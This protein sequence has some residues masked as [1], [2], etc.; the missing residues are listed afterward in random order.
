M[1]I[2]LIRHTAV[3]NPNKLCYGQSEIPLEENFTTHF[4][5]IED[6]LNEALTAKPLV[7]SSSL[8]RCTKLASFLSNDNYIV[9]ERLKEL[10]FGNWE[11]KSWDNI[12]PKEL[13]PWMADFVNQKPPNGE[14]FIEL[15]NRCNYFW[16]EITEKP[17]KENIIIVSHAGVIRSILANILGFPLQNAFNLQIDY[18]SITKINYQKEYGKQTVVYV[19]KTQC[20]SKVI[21]NES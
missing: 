13:N 8:R 12:N 2:Y 6:Y 11:L 10:S 4:N 3:Y 15:T 5:W 14:N 19:N 7:Y 1:D 20:P 9:D 18:A 21:G 17:S 16:D